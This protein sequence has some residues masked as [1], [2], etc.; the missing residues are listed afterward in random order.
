MRTGRASRAGMIARVAGVVAAGMGVAGVA[1]AAPPKYVIVVDSGNDV[2][3][4][5][6]AASGAMVNAAWIRY[7]DWGLDATSATPKDAI[8]VGNQLW[9]SDQVQDAIH[10]FTLSVSHPEYLGSIRAGLDNV[11]GMECHNGVV[12]ICNAGTNNGAP[13]PSVVM[14]NRRGQNLG[15]FTVGDPFDVTYRAS[16]GDLLIANASGDDLDRYSTSGAFLGKYHNSD[17]V[18]GINFPEQIAVDPSGVNDVYVTGFLSPAG[19]YAYKNGAQTAYV[20][21]AS[22]RGVAPLSPGKF[23]LTADTAIS[24]LTT[25]TGAITPVYTDS[26]ANFQYANS[27]T[28]YCPADMNADGFVN[29]DDYD[30]FASSFDAADAEADFNGDG[31]VNGDDYDAFSSAFDAGC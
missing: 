30:A 11:R 27:V 10:R 21:F 7:S 19:V 6:D 31:F 3:A 29:G 18:S 12:Y 13:G 16:A 8:R 15:Y 2:V 23:L 22:L 9:I 14:F 26:N 20:P 28:F 17:G 24:V 1:G 4:L 25:A 5:C